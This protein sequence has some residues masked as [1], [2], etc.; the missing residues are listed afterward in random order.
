MHRRRAHVADA[1]QRL[2]RR[3]RTCLC[4][5]RAS[6]AGRAR[7]ARPRG[8][9]QRCASSAPTAYARCPRAQ[10]VG[11]CTRGRG[12]PR[13]PASTALGSW[14][15]PRGPGRACS[16][17]CG[18]A[19]PPASTA[20]AARARRR[21]RRRTRGDAVPSSLVEGARVADLAHPAPLDGF[22]PLESASC[23]AA[24]RVRVARAIRARG[25][26]PRARFTL[27]LERLAIFSSADAIT[28]RRLNLGW[29][30]LLVCALNKPVRPSTAAG[31]IRSRA[32]RTGRR[33]NLQ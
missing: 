30:F 26:A 25:G 17:A 23:D 32:S 15:A 28:W 10:P 4:E 12:R 27:G 33:N 11:A 1:Q 24:S 2:A 3:R 31:S 9:G 6:A 16:G 22:A 8:A 29:L 19:A 18:P 20:A 14:W 13:P 21:Q 7:A 5:A